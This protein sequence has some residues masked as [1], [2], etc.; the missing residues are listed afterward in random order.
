MAD[1]P[2]FELRQDS[3]ALTTWT[4]EGDARRFAPELRARVVYV[5]HPWKNPTPHRGEMSKLVLG[6]WVEDSASR[7]SAFAPGPGGAG[8]RLSRQK[9]EAAHFLYVSDRSRAVELLSALEASGRTGRLW[10]GGT[11]S[12]WIVQ[13]WAGQAS[14]AKAESPKLHEIAQRYGGRYDGGEIIEGE[15]WGPL[16]V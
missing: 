13:I 11:P 10:G 1:W 4:R 6:L 5:E 16:P 8:Y 7:V 15:I 9:G 2:E 3:G 14:D 12:L